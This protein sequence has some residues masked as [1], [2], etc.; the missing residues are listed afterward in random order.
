MTTAA[1][2]M[3]VVAL[4]ANVLLVRGQSERE[5]ELWTD[6][7]EVT[8]F[9]VADWQKRKFQSG[10]PTFIRFGKRAMLAARESY[11]DSR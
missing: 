7:Q 4:L 8:S 9:K 11:R 5:D 2:V 10:R 6:R 3:L 1:H